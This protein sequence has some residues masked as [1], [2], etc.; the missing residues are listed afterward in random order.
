MLHWQS[1][2]SK[3]VVVR[4]TWKK[5]VVTMY[6]RFPSRPLW[7]RNGSNHNGK[8]AKKQLSNIRLA[9]FW[10][11]KWQDSGRSLSGYHTTF[12]VG[13]LM[14][15]L[16]INIKNVIYSSEKLIFPRRTFMLF[17][18]VGQQPLNSSS[19][20]SFLSSRHHSKLKERK[21]NIPRS[22]LGTFF[23]IRPRTS[24]HVKIT[25]LYLKSEV[26]EIRWQL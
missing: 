11:L 1:L 15:T 5:Q 21:I 24:E 18:F 2:Y 23:W 3:Q 10:R 4:S 8:Q 17:I 25:V 20:F 9:A 14:V 6:S 13:K 16:N 26:Y 22:E 19:T 7:N 12:A